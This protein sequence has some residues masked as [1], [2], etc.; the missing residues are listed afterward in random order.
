MDS[1]LDGEMA[2]KKMLK[3]RRALLTLIHIFPT[4]V[5]VKDNIFRIVFAACDKFCHLFFLVVFALTESGTF[6][7]PFVVDKLVDLVYT[8]VRLL[9]R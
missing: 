8:L 2:T 5:E 9:A 1:E 4:Y 6:V 7:C 3:K